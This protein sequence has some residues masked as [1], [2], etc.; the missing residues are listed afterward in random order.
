M[1]F[2]GWLSLGGALLMAMALSSAWIRRLPVSTA[3]I[4]LGVGM[5]L[6][7]WGFDLLRLDLGAPAPWFERFTELAVVLSLF[8]GGLRLRLPFQ[9]AAWHA[10]WWLASVAM[11]ATIAGV[12]FFGWWALGLSP[13]LALLLGAVLAPT[14]PVLAGSVTVGHSQDHDRVRYALSG[15]AGL[16]TAPPFR[17][18]HL[19]C[20][21]S[22]T[23][24]RHIALRTG[25]STMCSGPFPRVWPSGL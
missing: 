18:F 15:E 14:D 20:W 13:A 11:I 2:V 9:D 6:G 3:S 21:D 22:L 23:D 25:H 24:G 12:A 10:A 5:L 17:S 19:P 4:Y 8:V 1:T 7:P 16:N